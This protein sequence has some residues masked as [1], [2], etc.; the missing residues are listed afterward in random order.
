MSEITMRQYS[1][2]LH[3]PPRLRDAKIEVYE[4]VRESRYCDKIALNGA[5]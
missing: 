2:H 4:A 1:S 5:E 3:T